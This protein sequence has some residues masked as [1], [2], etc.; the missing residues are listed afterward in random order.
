MTPY[1]SQFDGKIRSLSIDPVWLSRVMNLSADDE[2]TRDAYNT[3]L[4]VI[5]LFH[6]SRYSTMRCFTRYNQVDWVNKEAGGRSR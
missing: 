3:T 6:A 1:K 2:W 4:A 5:G